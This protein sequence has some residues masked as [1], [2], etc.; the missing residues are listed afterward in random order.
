[1]NYFKR[2]WKY[3]CES[4]YDIRKAMEN[5]LYQMPQSG[6]VESPQVYALKHLTPILNELYIYAMTAELFKDMAE[7]VKKTTEE[8]PEIKTS[9]SRP[10]EEANGDN[11]SCNDIETFAKLCEEQSEEMSKTANALETSFIKLL[12]D[13]NATANSDIQNSVSRIKDE[14]PRIKSEACFFT[15]DIIK[16]EIIGQL[17]I[18]HYG[19]I[20]QKVTGTSYYD[21]KSS[22]TIPQ[23]GFSL[24]SRVMDIQTFFLGNNDLSIQTLPIVLIYPEM[25]DSKLTSKEIKSILKQREQALKLYSYSV[26]MRDVVYPHMQLFGCLGAD[27]RSALC[28]YFRQFPQQE[29]DYISWLCQNDNV[30]GATKAQVELQSHTILHTESVKKGPLAEMVFKNTPN[31]AT[32]IATSCF[33][34]KTRLHIFLPRPFQRGT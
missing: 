1:M 30:N 7:Q 17:S 12:D 32:L 21:A 3:T 9:F 5:N 14:L 18:S 27:P 16:S 25:T 13:P 20:H 24:R 19:N 28:D 4:I 10:K 23:E 8:I 2:L 31:E 6:D 29:F 33:G 11:Q 34:I 15:K 22:K 26:I